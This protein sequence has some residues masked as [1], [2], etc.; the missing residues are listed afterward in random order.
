[1]ESRISDC[2][3]LHDKGYNCAQAVA[4]AYADLV[5]A[6]KKAL[7]AATEGLGLGMGGMEGTC[8]ALSGACIVCG[9]AK[10]GADLENPT[11]K[12]ATYKVSRELVS[13]FAELSG[14]TRCRDLKGIDTGTVLCSC[15]QCIENAA[16]VL[17]DVVFS[18]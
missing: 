13:R 8:G 5:G 14:A 7:F 16:R 4:C 9:L 1:M 12:G 2:A 10:S 15:P 11:T 17:E 3:A 18:D 6:D